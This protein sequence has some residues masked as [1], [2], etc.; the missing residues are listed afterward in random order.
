MTSTVSTTI[1]AGASDV[2]EI[3]SDGWLFGLWVVGASR[4]RNVDDSW[5]APGSEIHHSVGSW[6]L[7]LDDT[8]SVVTCVANAALGL[9][10]RAWPGG[11][12]RVDITIEGQGGRSVVTMSEDVTH[13]PALMI[14]SVVRRAVLD[15]RNKESL[16]RLTYLVEQRARGS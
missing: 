5:P 16:K 10:A 4:I 3:L 12:A 8:T 6:P 2:W 14:P 15:P 13:G 1:E 9:Q 11:E 7:M